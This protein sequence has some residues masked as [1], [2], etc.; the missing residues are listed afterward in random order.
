[1]FIS[2][3]EKSGGNEIFMPGV[4]VPEIH[5]IEKKC[6]YRAKK[7]FEPTNNLISLS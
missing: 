2:E 7:W 4:W 3:K 5:G 1:L 6:F